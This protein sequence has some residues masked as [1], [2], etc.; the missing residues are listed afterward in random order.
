MIISKIAKQN[1]EILKQRQPDLL[2]SI[3]LPKELSE[4]T[5]REKGAVAGLIIEYVLKSGGTPSIFEDNIDMELVTDG[6]YID[7]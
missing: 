5:D 4:L 2:K 1:I 6:E 3:E 7:I